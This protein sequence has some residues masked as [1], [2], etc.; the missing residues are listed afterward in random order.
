MPAGFSLSG[1]PITTQGTLQVGF[2]SGYGLPKTEDVSKGVAAYGWGDHSQ[3]GYGTVK[4][5]GLTVPT[6]FS[7]SGSPVTVQGNLQIAFANG[8]S[9]PLTT[10]VEKGVTAYGWGDHSQEGYIKAVTYSMIV[11]ALGFAPAEYADV[12]ALQTRMD[13]AEDDIDALEAAIGGTNRGLLYAPKIRIYEGYDNAHPQLP[14]TPYMLVEHP[15]LDIAN[16]NARCVLM[17]WSKRRGRI[18]ATSTKNRPTYTG[19]WGEVRGKYATTAPL[20]WTKR[21]NLDAIRQFVLNNCLCGSYRLE[22]T[23]RTMLLSSFNDYRKPDVLFGFKGKHAQLP[24]NFKAKESRLFGV[25]IRYQNPEWIKY[26]AENPVETT[27]EIDGEQGVKIKRYI[28]SDVTPF[29]IHCNPDFNS[30]WRLGF[31]LNPFVG[32]VKL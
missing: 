2:E 11:T 14:F 16:L 20:T 28:Y 30:Y 7:V 22:S 23:M 21:V 18:G 25:A 12:N 13:N 24:T 32:P 17:V 31:Q 6:G 15:L 5:V 1:S 19:G 29:R 8:Y 9:L 26:A 4:S 10:D 3:A 27:R